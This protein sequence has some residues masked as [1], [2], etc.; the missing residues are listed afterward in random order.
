MKEKDEQVEMEKARA[1]SIS[2]YPLQKE[3]MVKAALRG[4]VSLSQ[5]FQDLV[6]ADIARAKRKGAK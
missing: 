3:H 4:G 1:I 5:Y 2:L 6:D